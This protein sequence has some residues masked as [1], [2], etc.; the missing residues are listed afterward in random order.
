VKKILQGKWFLYIAECRDKTLYTG[1]AK[2]VAR[3]IKEHN[4]TAWCK[5]TRSRKPVKLVYCEKCGD[6]STAR[7]REYEVK[8][9]SREKKQ[10]LIGRKAT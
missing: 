1:I 2:D 10:E 6:C 3:R 4:T 5:Y 7:K 9:W 8:R